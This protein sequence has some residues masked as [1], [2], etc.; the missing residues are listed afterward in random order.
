MRRE[1]AL[2]VALGHAVDP[3]A[4]LIRHEGMLIPGEALFDHLRKTL[5]ECDLGFRGECILI[6]EDEDRM[7]LPRSLDLCADLLLEAAR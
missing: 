3:V 7:L 4:I 5:D 6:P 1:R 2:A